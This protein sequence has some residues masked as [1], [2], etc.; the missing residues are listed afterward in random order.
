MSKSTKLKLTAI[1]LTTSLTSIPANATLSRTNTHSTLPPTTAQLIIAR[2]QYDSQLLELTNAQ[3]RRQNLPPLRFSPQLGQAAQ[4]HAEDMVRNRFF[5]HT[6]SNGSSLG[7]RVKA[8]G[9]SYSYIGENISAGRST[10]TEAIQGW[11]NSSGHR[12]NILNREYTEIGFGYVT[13][14]SSPYRYYWVQVFGKSRN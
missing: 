6:G 13:S 14:P 9:Y 5:S 11:M 4:R 12:A 3:R 7:D 2:S 1:A 10:P 8:T